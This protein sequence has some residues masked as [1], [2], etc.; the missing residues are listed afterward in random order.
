MATDTYKTFYSGQPATTG[1]TLYTAPAGGA[2]MKH[3][4]VVNTDT[5]DR[6][7][8]F[9]RNGTDAAHQWTP[10][11]VVKANSGMC[12]FDGTEALG[13]GDTLYAVTS[14]NTKLTTT[15]SGDELS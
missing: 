14:V 15:V 10:V 2:I 7:I 13:S 11:M 8:Q 5:V 9:F 4:S 12:E 6:T 3:I 1:T